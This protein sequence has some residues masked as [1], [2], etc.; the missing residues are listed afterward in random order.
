MPNNF[1]PKIKNGIVNKYIGIYLEMSS[2]FFKSNSIYIEIAITNPIPVKNIYGGKSK[3]V[4]PHVLKLN[5]PP[6]IKNYHNSSIFLEH[7]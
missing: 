7:L 1:A 4:K 3:I 6:P 2:L 5:Q